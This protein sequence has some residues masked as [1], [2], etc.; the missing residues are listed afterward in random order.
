ME[1]PRAPLHIVSKFVEET[2]VPILLKPIKI[3]D[4]W[5]RIVFSAIKNFGKVRHDRIAR[6]HEPQLN[7][8]I[9]NDALRP[10]ISSRAEVVVAGPQLVL[11]TERP[12]SIILCSKHQ[13]LNPFFVFVQT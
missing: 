9:W 11:H 5:D 4:P 13:Q 6:V 2:P 1:C 3:K 10:S 12:H 7:L 8:H